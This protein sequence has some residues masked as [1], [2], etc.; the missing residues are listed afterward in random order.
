[1]PHT[2]SGASQ[3]IEVMRSLTLLMLNAMSAKPQSLA[4]A[5]FLYV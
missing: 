5:T 4:I 1:M 3:S 2:Q